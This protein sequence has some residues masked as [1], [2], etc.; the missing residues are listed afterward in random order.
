MGVLISRF[1][2]TTLI[3]FIEYTKELW[4]GWTMKITFAKIK[5]ETWVLMII[6]GLD[7]IVAITH[8]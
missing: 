6:I 5:E 7:Y 8:S 4:T 3:M 1:F 2:I